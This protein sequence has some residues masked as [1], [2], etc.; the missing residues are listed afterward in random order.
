MNSLDVKSALVS[1]II[2]SYNNA[3][4]LCRAIDSVIGQTY[5]KIEIIV[6]NDCSP[7]SDQIE[8]LLQRYPQVRYI[9]NP[10]NVGA[11]ASRNLGIGVAQGEIL[12]FL[13]ADDEYVADKIS[14]QVQALEPGIAVT[15]GLTRVH[16]DG[17]RVVEER[18]SRVIDI[19]RALEYRNTI[20]GAGLLVARDLLMEHGGYDSSLR[21][22]ED[23]DLWLRLLDSGVKIKDIGLPLYLYHKSSVGLSSNIGTAAPAEFEVVRR[24]V[25][26]MG[27][28]WCCR[29]RYANVIAFALLRLS[30]KAEIGNIKELRQMALEH[31]RL[32]SAFPIAHALVRLIISARLMVMPAIL[33]RMRSQRV[34]GEY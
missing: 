28:E 7:D 24:H 34:L 23:Y 8:A 11:S 19:P 6:V 31:C 15:C 12:A 17:R 27:P 1:V 4:T 21:A 26:R 5:P 10:V 33:S 32:L 3:A 20:N 14:L 16:H 25:V 22:A 2:P 29:S 9:R 18:L 30:L 13:D